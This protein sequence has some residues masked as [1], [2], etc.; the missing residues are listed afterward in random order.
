[1]NDLRSIDLNLLVVLDALLDEAHVTRAAARLRLSQPATSSALDRL[2][3][4]FGDR[5]LER[6]RGGMR[7][8]P[9]GERLQPPLKAALAAIRATLNAQPADI[10]TVQQTVRLVMAD[11]PAAA[12]M[13]ALMQRLS[14]TAPGVT[15]AVLPWRGAAEAVGQLGRGDVELVASVLPPLGPAFRQATLFQE[16]YVVAMRRGH[17]A[18][19]AFD[20]GRWLAYPHCVV[21][22]R[23]E[24]AT[25]LDAELAALGLSRRVGA[26]VPSFLMV[27]SLLLG[28]NL[29]AMVPSM[30]L[31][32][33]AAASLV[34]FPPPVAVDGFQ[35]GLAWHV[36]G[37]KDIVVRHVVAEIVA[38]LQPGPAS[39]VSQS[40]SGSV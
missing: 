2:R 34:T 13:A 27:P 15:I 20:L 10:A 39:L 35:L 6:V 16:R 17:P 14:I 19:A 26:V 12:V 18:S 33:D 4:L 32:L 37:D 40:D 24:A 29:I 9:A 23:G 30:C 22:G 8:T 21:S 3:H 7:L 11:T 5:L 31:P 1:M 36:R 25:P 28:S 38:M